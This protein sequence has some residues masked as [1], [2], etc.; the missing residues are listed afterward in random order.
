MLTRIRQFDGSQLVA[1]KKEGS[2]WTPAKRSAATR[3][4]WL[5]RPRAKELIKFPPPPKSD[6]PNSLAAFFDAHDKADVTVHEILHSTELDPKTGE[7]RESFTNEERQEI[8]DRLK[9]VKEATPTDEVYGRP[10]PPPKENK[11]YDPER[12]ALHEA[13]VNK[14]L[15]AEIIARA[16]PP[17][18]TPPTMYVLAGRGGSGKS[19][20]THED[21]EDGRPGKDQVIKEFDS[22]K[23]LVMDSDKIKTM[24]KPPYEGW[25]AGQVHEEASHVFDM[26]YNEAKKRGLNMVY[27][28]TMKSKSAEDKIVELQKL[29]YEV[30]GHMMLVPRQDTAVRA[31]KRYLGKGPEARGRLVPVD[32]ILENTK[33]ERNF[34]YMKKY[35]KRWTAYENIGKPPPKPLPANFQQDGKE[36]S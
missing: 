16:T 26:L 6:D 15:S 30:E 7:M 27:D 12:V 13:I 18:G 23:T 5:S 29:G 10:N 36:L 24:L 25:N 14:L 8:R 2:G 3:K 33:N 21:P 31:V 35:F 4:S 1:H 19:A 17:E 20:F 32:V 28:A 9:E 11:V 22:K 34:D